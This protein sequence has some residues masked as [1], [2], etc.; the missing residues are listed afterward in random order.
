MLDGPSS[1]FIRDVISGFE[2][3]E[4][5]ETELWTTLKTALRVFIGVLRCWRVRIGGDAGL[6]MRSLEL[7]L[8][9]WFLELWCLR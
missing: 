2:A 9:L 6:R 4:G 1:P 7:L 5:F 3:R 8:N